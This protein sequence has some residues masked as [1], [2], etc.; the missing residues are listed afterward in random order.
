MPEKDKS[1]EEYE[2]LRDEIIRDKVNEIFATEPGNYRNA[3]EEIGFTWHDD[4]SPSEEEEENAAVPEN[5]RQRLLVSYFEGRAEPS[6]SMVDALLA[7]KNA[8]EPNYPLVRKYFRARN[9]PLKA[10]ILFGLQ[11]DP[12][13]FDLLTDLFFFNDF[14]RN[15]PELI[16]HLTKACQLEDDPRKFSEIALEF[17]YNTQQDGYDALAALKDIFAEDSG[18]R[19]VIDFLINEKQRQDGEDIWF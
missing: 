18:K 19:K 3:L 14:D 4:E 8:E 6:V 16:E 17:Y 1:A 9:R 12:T 2:K 5:D 15:L 10:L 13:N 11:N 7:E